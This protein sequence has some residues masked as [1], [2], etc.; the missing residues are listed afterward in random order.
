M[1]IRVHI[2]WAKVEAEAGNTE[3]A[4]DLLQKALTIATSAQDTQLTERIENY[5]LGLK[6]STKVDWSPEDTSSDL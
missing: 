1:L 5:F 3:K 4:K 2:S 6:D